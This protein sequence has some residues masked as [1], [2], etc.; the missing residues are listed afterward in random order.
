MS[1]FFSW[2]REWGLSPPVGAGAKPVV[3]YSKADLDA[4]ALDILHPLPKA[5]DSHYGGTVEEC[6]RVLG[7]LRELRERYAS[8][9]PA[10]LRPHILGWIDWAEGRAKEARADCLTQKSKRR[11]E[12]CSK[13]WDDRR[14]RIRNLKRELGVEN[15]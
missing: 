2:L 4:V 3:K 13:E 14:E 10:L 8:Y 11:A 7:R 6:D 15:G 9:E 5:S 1:G 12:E